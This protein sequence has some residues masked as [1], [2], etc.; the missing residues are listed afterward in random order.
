MKYFKIQKGF[1]IDD[2]ISIDETE[3]PM[4]MRAQITGKIG[5]FN[6]GT[7][8]GKSIISITPDFNREM[9]YNRDYRMDGEDYARL[10]R[11]K[12][13][14]YRDLITHTKLQVENQLGSGEVKQLN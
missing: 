2:Y 1:N 12:S 7:I 14:E 13:N 5:V 6:E 8:Q 11:R 10:G 3:L 4:A 9:G